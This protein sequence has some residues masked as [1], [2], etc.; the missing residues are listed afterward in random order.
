MRSAWIKW[1]RAFE[2]QQVLARGT[3][4]QLGGAEPLCE[5]VR[6]DNAADNSDPLIKAHWRLKVKKDFPER[7]SVLIG[8]FLTNL[9]AALDHAF[10]AAAVQHSGRPARPAQLGFPITTRAS[11]FARQARELRELVSPEVWRVVEATQPFHGGAEA[12]TSPLEV[13]RV[14][15]NVDKHRF[16]HVLR[17]AYIDLAPVDIR[18]E[19]PLEVVEEWH[20]EGLAEDNDVILRL[21]LKRPVNTG[22]VDLTP[23]FSY[24]PTIQISE[25]PVEYRTLDSAVEAM[26]TEVLEVISAINATMGLPFPDPHSFEL[27]L[28]HTEVATE[29]AGSV[30]TF[31]GLDGAVQRFNLS[32]GEPIALSQPEGRDET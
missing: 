16:V 4:E 26:L 32:T 5:Y 15:S 27:G 3:R 30:L 14:L 12:H 1:A 23:V 25:D 10:W 6:W 29:Y 2:H 7:W 19:V 18:S 28:E 9:R 31:R 8:D 11:A 22:P 24:I 20:H 17:R 13:L 21:K